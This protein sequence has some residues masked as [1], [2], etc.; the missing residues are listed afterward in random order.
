MRYVKII[1]TG[2]TSDFGLT[3]I[4]K[5]L[6]RYSPTQVRVKEMPLWVTLGLVE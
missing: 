4:A 2:Y 5:L 6:T 3:A 1:L